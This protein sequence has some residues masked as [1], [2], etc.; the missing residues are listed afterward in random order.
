MSESDLSPIPE[1]L[2]FDD[3]LLVPQRSAASS[4][5]DVDLTA[6]FS[7]NICLRLPILSANVPWVTEAAMAIAMAREGALGVLHRMNTIDEQV[8]MAHAVAKGL[9][10]AGDANVTHAIVCGIGVRED[11]MERAEALVGAGAK[12]LVIDIAHGH[13]DHTL[14][15]LEKLRSRFDGGIDLIAGNVCTA[16]G[17]RDLIVAG[18]DAVKVGIGPGG[19][20]TTRRV[21]GAG[22][23]QFTAIRLCAAEAA[24][25][26]VPVIA[27]GGI[28][29]S[30][31]IVKALAAG[32]SSVM[33]G[34]MLGG[35]TESASDLFETPAG[36]IK[37]TTGF[38]TLGTRAFLDKK[39]GKIQS[40]AARAAYV[41]EGIETFFPHQGPVVGILK[42]LKGGMQSGF[43][44]GGALTLEQLWRNAQ[45]VRMTSSGKSESTPHAER[46]LDTSK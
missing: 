34:S 24:R 38:A 1:A 20:C 19:I 32:A 3:V 18:A 36:A 26:G 37:R 5:S 11:G 41:P 39:A 22:M 30:G 44:Y 10:D 17:T 43:S 25:H 2:A 13:S 46:R 16:A 33:L 14:A 45:F 6:R 8:A 4:R 42:Q 7:R 15:L 23:P 29:S 27:D 40:E 21:A 12:A 31:D 9:A 35:A 28:R